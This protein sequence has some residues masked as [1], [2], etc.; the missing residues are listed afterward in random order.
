MENKRVEIAIRIDG[1]ECFYVI[2]EGF[3][4]LSNQCHGLDREVAETIRST[5]AIQ[6]MDTSII[7]LMVVMASSRMTF[8]EGVRVEVALDEKG[9]PAV[10]NPETGE[11]D[12]ILGD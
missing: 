10:R 12:S 6:G 9:R 11:V 8:P 4:R 7:R 2:P 1:N 3:N 5:V